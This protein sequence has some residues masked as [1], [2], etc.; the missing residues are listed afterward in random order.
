[1]PIFVSLS[2]KFRINLS[3]LSVWGL[4]CRVVRDADEL[5]VATSGTAERGDH[6]VDPRTGLGLTKRIGVTAIARDGITCDWLDTAVAVLGREKGTE[7]V[8]SIPGA[9]ARIT[10]IDDAGRITVSETSRFSQ[11][12]SRR[13]LA[14]P[15][16]GVK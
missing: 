8:E 16:K 1:M 9:A 7:L 2:S 5:A 4:A 10:T 15:D 11:Y 14:E 12:V 13:P 3:L 6:I